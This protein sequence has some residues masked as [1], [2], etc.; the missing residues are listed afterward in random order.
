MEVLLEAMDDAGI[1][2][3]L[4]NVEGGDLTELLAESNE[5]SGEYNGARSP[6]PSFSDRLSPN[7]KSSSSRTDLKD[8][9]FA[10][11]S[12][13]MQHRCRRV[14]LL[15][16]LGFCSSRKW[17]LISCLTVSQSRNFQEISPRHL[18]RKEL[19]SLLSSERFLMRTGEQNLESSLLRKSSWLLISARRQT[20]ENSLDHKPVV[21]KLVICFYSRVVKLLLLFLSCFFLLQ[22]FYI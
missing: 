18:E 6:Q 11:V 13:G 14:H 19:K 3:T 1:S 16:R 8:L 15:V 7:G 21:T 17:K 9:E 2:D 5:L 4:G 10:F 12:P 22:I 20:N